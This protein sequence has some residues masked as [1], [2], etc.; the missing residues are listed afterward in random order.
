VGPPIVDV[1]GQ[2][3][4]RLLALERVERKSQREG[5]SYWLCLCDCG[6]EI[7]TRSSCLRRGESQSCGCLMSELK[8]MESLKHGCSSRGTGKPAT[9]EYTAWLSAKRRC[10][11]TTRKHFERYGG[12]G[13]TV[14]DGWRNNFE[15]FLSDVGPKPSPKLSIDRKDNDGH[16]SCGHC[17]Q[18]IENGWPMNCRWAT[19][20]EQIRNQRHPRKSRRKGR[21]LFMESI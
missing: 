3:F 4:G 18:C 13:I 9:T 21:R 14:C 5:R 19:Q 1:T 11:D 2:R 20:K 16:Y 12:R 10:F 17:P 6:N 7:I 15:A 8:R